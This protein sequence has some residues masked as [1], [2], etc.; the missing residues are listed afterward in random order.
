MA[1]AS[2]QFEPNHALGAMQKPRI[3]LLDKARWDYLQRRYKI[4]PRELEVAK[5]ICRGCGNEE[6]AETLRI[7]IGTV[8]VHVRNIYRK[9]WVENKILMLLR[10]V[11]DSD[12]FF[13]GS[14]RPAAG[15]H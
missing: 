11:E 9:T 15:P 4:T 14:I 8:K 12:T 10:F 13:N 2:R 5:L 7:T 3:V 1:E 6:I